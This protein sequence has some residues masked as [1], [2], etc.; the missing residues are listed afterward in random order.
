MLY[1]VVSSLLHFSLR[2]IKKVPGVKLVND[3]IDLMKDNT[4]QQL[5][6]IKEQVL[7]GGIVL[8]TLGIVIWLAIFMYIAFYYTY[9]PQLTHTR[10][11]HLQ[12]R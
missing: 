7:K 11:V 6:R 2:M 5:R 10:P 1:T 8:L 9:I 4:Q 12:F 3:K